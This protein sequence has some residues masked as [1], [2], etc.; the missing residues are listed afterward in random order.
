MIDTVRINI[1]AGDGGNGCLSF[2]REKFL[3]KGGPNGG[4][5]GDGGSAYMVGDPSINT[6]LHLKYNSTFYVDRGQHGKGKNQRGAN[7]KDTIIK[8]P[9][10]T[11]VWKMGRHGSVPK[12]FV[13]DIID[14]EPRLVARGG[15]GGW[16]NLHY[17][18]STNQEPMLAQK[19]ESGE[20]VVLFLELKLL[21][22]VGL[23]AKPNAGK[24]TLISRC[25]AARPRIADYPFTTVEPVLGVVN[26]RRQDFVM[27]EVPGLI[28]GAHEGV[29]LGQQ[30]LRHAERARL[31]VHLIDGLSDNPV[32]DFL[33]INEELGK[34]SPALADKPQ[35]VAVSKVDVTE[36]RERRQELESQLQGVLEQCSSPAT[37]ESDGGIRVFFISAVT[38]EGIDDLLDHILELLKSLPKDEPVII[39]QE[40][41]PQVPDHSSSGSRRPLGF[42][43]EDGVYVVESEQL[44]RFSARA[45][46]HDYRVM[47]QLWREMSRLGIA[48]KLEEA[49]IAPGDTIRIGK[50][51]MEWF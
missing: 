8:V 43:I 48:R 51:E 11:V 50:A 10:G 1:K 30:F 47:L 3:P 45:N 9:L 33:M 7:G 23:I 29:G 36:V 49:G 34:F 40:L 27:M 18:S 19:G 4:D 13:A 20:Y 32:S 26:H 6:L 31:Y 14:E 35:V 25:S 16:G 24:S 21:A 42:R 15:K 44:E 22:D 28:E 39:D 5:G 37:E 46:L 38:G 41:L 12:E 2:L 17:V